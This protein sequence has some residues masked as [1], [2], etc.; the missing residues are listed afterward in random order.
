[1][2]SVMLD[3]KKAFDTVDHKILLG[4]L[5]RIGIRGL[6]L[7]WHRSYLSNRKQIVDVGVITLWRLNL[8]DV[9]FLKDRI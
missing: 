5:E 9:L 6:P 1:M 7:Q 4:K 8:E 3:F 2:V